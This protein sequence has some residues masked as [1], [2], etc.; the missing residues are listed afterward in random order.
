M[1]VGRAIQNLWSI[2]LARQDWT[3]FVVRMGVNTSMVFSRDACISGTGRHLHRF[4]DK[5]SG[6]A[7][8]SNLVDNIPIRPCSVVSPSPG[9][10]DDILQHFTVW[11]QTACDHSAAHS[12]PRISAGRISDGNSLS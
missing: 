1:L 10:L 5:V 3:S 8:M 9:P 7:L 6:L 2:F 11:P 4:R 12:H